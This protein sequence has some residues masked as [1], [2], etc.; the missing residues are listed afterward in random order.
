MIEIPHRSSSRPDGCLVGDRRQSVMRTG[1]SVRR[2]SV[3]S[4]LYSLR[5]WM[6]TPFLFL[7][8]T[9][10]LPRIGIRILSPSTDLLPAAFPRSYS[11]RQLP[12]IHPIP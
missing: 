7:Q 12:I 1:G 9:G 6:S 5:R 10:F 8:L 4:R 2:S 11:H 3:S